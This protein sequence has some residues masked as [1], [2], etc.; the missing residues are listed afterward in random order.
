RLTHD[1]AEATRALPSVAHVGLFH[2]AYAVS[3]SL[4]GA[5]EP[6]T[7]SSLR[8]L[9]VTVPPDDPAGN[10]TL[11]FFDAIDPEERRDDLEA[12]GATIVSGSPHGFRVRAPQARIRDI[13]HVP[14]LLAAE[15][16]THMELTNNNSGVILGTNQI[17]AVGAVNFLVNL[18][19]R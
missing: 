8:N 14:G 19:G 15:L 17:R 10:L 16:P 11:R 12:A 5:S 13:L 9:Q 18:D 2:P 7:A 3:P 1:Q 6:F 4:A